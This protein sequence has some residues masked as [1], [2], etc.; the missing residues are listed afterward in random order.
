VD[1]WS[2]FKEGKLIRREVDTR[3]AGRPD[4]VY[5]Y[6]GDQIAREERDETGQGMITYRASYE[7]GRLAK[8]EKDSAG[9][10]RTDL[11]T[12]YDTASDGEIV[13]REE[14][15]LNGDGHPDIWSHFE[16]G[17]LARRDVSA[18]GLQILSRKEQLPTPPD[19]ELLQVSA[20]GQ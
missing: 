7:N 9:S 14:R 15:D 11:W 13:L 19:A 12:Y 20:P 8:I 5:F 6:N 17:R 16:N 10:G 18:V 3:Q 2:Y 4:R 1:T